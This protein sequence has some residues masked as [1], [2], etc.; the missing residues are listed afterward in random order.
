MRR[1]LSIIIPLF[2]LF[3]TAE[4]AHLDLAWSPND[5]TDLGGYRVYYGLESRDYIGSVDVGRATSCLLDNL[6][7]DVPY[8][9][10]LTAY[11]TGGNESGF[12]QEVVGV[13]SPDEEVPASG[14]AAIDGSD[15]GCFVSAVL[16]GDASD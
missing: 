1:I 13:G 2:F 7:E 15:G 11:D 6:M 16:R 9:I 8:Y 10:A 5:E 12:S 3:A 4:A 14:T